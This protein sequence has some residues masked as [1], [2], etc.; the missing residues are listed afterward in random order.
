MKELYNAPAAELIVFAAMEKLATGE[1]QGIPYND[2]PEGPATDISQGV[3][4]NPPWAN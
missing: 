4:T 2:D 3:G 1:H